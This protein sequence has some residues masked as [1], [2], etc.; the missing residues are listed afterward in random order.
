MDYIFVVTAIQFKN[1]KNV[2]LAAAV[3]AAVVVVV[4]IVIDAITV[5]M[6]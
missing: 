5:T 4:I 3:V 2:V 6:S 1:C